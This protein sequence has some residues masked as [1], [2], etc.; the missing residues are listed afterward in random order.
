MPNISK[1]ISIGI[2]LEFLA[3][4]QKAKEIERQQIEQAYN[5]G[6]REAEIDNGADIRDDISDYGNASNYFNQTYQ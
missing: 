6:Y 1:H 4:F 3:K 2:A 5:Q